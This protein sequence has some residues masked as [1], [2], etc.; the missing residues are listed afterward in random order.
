MY[1]MDPF[2]IVNKEHVNPFENVKKYGVYHFKT[3]KTVEA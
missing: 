1:S 2:K 3:V